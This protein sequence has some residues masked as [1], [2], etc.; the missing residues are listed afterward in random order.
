MELL[1]ALRSLAIPKPKPFA[2]MYAPG[3]KVP[4]KPDPKQ[5]KAD[6]DKLWERDDLW[7]SLVTTTLRW[8]D[9]SLTG[10]FPEDEED[11]ALGF[12]EEYISSALSDE[13]NLVIAKLSTLKTSVRKK[14]ADDS[15][16][17]RAQQIEDA[18]VW[19]LD[20]FAHRW[21]VSGQRPLTIDRGTL[22]TDYG[23]Y[24]SRTTFDADNPECPLDFV[25]IDPTEAYPVWEGRKGLRAMHR[26]YRD[27]AANIA[28][29]YGDF[30]GPAKKRLEDKVGKMT[31][32][33][34]FSVYE[35]WD[36]W[37]R[38][39]LV[40]DEEILP[41]TAHKYGEVPFTVQYGG[42]GNP[43]FT[44]TPPVSVVERG[45]GQ[46][47]RRPSGRVDERASK[48][49][50][51]IYYRIK[52]HEMYE[53]IMARLVTGFKKEINPPLVR[54]RSNLAAEKDLMPF[55]YSPGA[56]NETLMGEERISP[57]PTQNG[58]PVTQTLLGNLSQD[59]RSGSMPQEAFGNID[60]SNVTGVAMASAGDAGWD[61]LVPLITALEHATSR[62]I[63]LGLRLIRNFGHL[64]KYGHEGEQGVVVTGRRRARPKAGFGAG[65]GT[66]TG[67]GGGDYELTP[68]II[69]AVGPRVKVSFTKVDPRDW[70]G[71]FQSGA[72]GVDKGF[73]TR[74]EIRALAMGDHDFDRFLEEY[75]EEQ[76]VFQALQEPN[77]AKAFLIPHAI[78]EEIKESEGNPRQQA[79]LKAMLDNWNQLNAPPPP[80]PGPPP[81][82]APPGGPPP[83]GPG[84]APFD[85]AAGNPM[86]G[87]SPGTSA[88]VSFP[89]LGQGPGS[90]GAPV[91]RPPF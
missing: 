61:K 74:A 87:P 84:G 69:D 22:L 8:L 2:P 73:V 81:G 1:A 68:E 39:V 65:A 58:G 9:Q 86:A 52:N 72:M 62:E 44:K 66:Q 36:S 54:E 80:Q 76:A 85:A 75:M 45:S 23:M 19:M 63:E 13:R 51:L 31:D 12:Q 55:D 91:G 46:W 41:V 89:Q 14:V 16:K 11:R 29:A 47:I 79:M 18:G 37:W 77:F 30:T 4:D 56:Q 83:G 50:P 78:M 28:R 17:Y 35:Y 64:S 82:M 27:T 34:E 49:V 70:S 10:M 5:I 88:G 21:S 24:V 43:M 7:R 71:I 25:L 6:T 33:T 60:K 32:E 53:A 42:M 40:G 26:H 38:C 67:A 48:S 15:L 57:V 3:Y 59:R 90:Q 20:E